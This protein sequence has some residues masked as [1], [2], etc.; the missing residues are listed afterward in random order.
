LP[1]DTVIKSAT[2]SKT[3]TGKYYI[4]VLLEYEIPITPVIPTPKTVLGLD[5]SSPSLFVDSQANNADYPGFYRQS[6]IMLKKAQ[7]KLSLRKKGG[8]NR[9]KQRLKVAKLHEKT[10]NQ[11]KDF[12]HKLSRQMSEAWDVV[13][14]E[15][16]NM[17]N[18]ARGLNLAKLPMITVLVCSGLFLPTSLLIW[19]NN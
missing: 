10:A 5:Y 17:R 14:I 2:I 3:P 6:E 11:R 19:A 12:L 13:A 7:R 9:E 15:D 18:M 4:S 16:L 8:K 1:Q